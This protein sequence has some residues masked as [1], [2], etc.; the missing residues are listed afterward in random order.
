[1]S[2]ISSGTHE[3][4][5]PDHQR[6]DLQIDALLSAGVHPSD[7]YTD[8]ISGATATH[9]RPGLAEA[10][11][12]C[13][14]NSTLVV[15]RVDRLGRSLVDVV[16]T[17]EQLTARGVAVRSISDGINP[18]TAQGRLMLHLLCSCAQFERELIQDRVRAGIES[19]RRRGV[20][21]GRPAPDA[22]EVA[23]KLRMAQR[24][25]SEDGLS[26]ADAARLVGWTDLPSTDICMPR[27]H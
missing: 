27:K 1:M 25:V 15:W 19:A 4:S 16:T 24:A 21:L 6:H 20:R 13:G 8:T 12:R 18:S 7:I 11:S 14:P 2:E 3:S 17:V 10:L 26:V 23:A 9:S 22:A 5:S